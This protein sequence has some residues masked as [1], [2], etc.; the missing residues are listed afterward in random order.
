M[1]TSPSLKQQ[2]YSLCIHL[3]NEKIQTLQQALKELTE[4]A[5]NETKSTAGDKHETALAMLQ[6]EQE[7]INR[8]LKTVLDQ[9]ASIETLNIS[10][11]HVA[12]G[13]GSLVKTNKGYLFVSVALGKTMVDNIPVVLLSPQS[14]LGKKLLGLKINDSTEI[15]G[16]HYTVEE[17]E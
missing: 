13:S 10:S 5:A 14:P 8:Q 9:K 7:N 15:N 12:V 16:M 6:I 1:L 17:I 4:S 2:A 11:K 3:L